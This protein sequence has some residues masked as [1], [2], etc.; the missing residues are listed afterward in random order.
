MP[1]K[2]ESTSGCSKIIW[3]GLVV[4]AS[5]DPAPPAEVD[6]SPQLQEGAPA[7]LGLPQVVLS[8]NPA[9]YRQDPAGSRSSSTG[10]KLGFEDEDAA[11]GR[12]EVVGLLRS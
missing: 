4:S 12:L 7:L 10:P 11:S 8:P 6:P 3:H 5:G 2:P 9:L 1:K